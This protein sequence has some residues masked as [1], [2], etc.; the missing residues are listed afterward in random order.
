MGTPAMPDL[1]QHCSRDDCHQLDFLPFTC[2]ACH[3]VLPIS[4]PPLV[5]EFAEFHLL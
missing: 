3:K 5:A 1:G 4:C 2:N